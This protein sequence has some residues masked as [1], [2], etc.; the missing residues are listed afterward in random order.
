MTSPLLIYECDCCG[1]E[2]TSQ[3]LAGEY[4]WR[5]P[6][7]AE[8]PIP[9]RIGV[10]HDCRSVVAVEKLPSNSD[11]A[12]AISRSEQASK[13]R[14]WRRRSAIDVKA[15]HYLDAVV[16]HTVSLNVLLAVKKLRTSPLCLSCASPNV[17]TISDETLI[18]DKSRVAT[19]TLHP[20]CGGMIFVRATNHWFASPVSAKRIYNIYGELIEIAENFY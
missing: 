13:L 18:I 11:V 12:K 9:R 8:A 17:G 5:A 3:L 1:H 2:K 19:G 4:V 6:N 7:G 16:G 10:C 14:L 20:H 15:D